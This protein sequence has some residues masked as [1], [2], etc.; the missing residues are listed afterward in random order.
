MDVIMNH[1]VNV[2]QIAM[3]TPQHNPSY[4]NNTHLASFLPDSFLDEVVKCLSPAVPFSG[5]VDES[6]LGLVVFAGPASRPA[7]RTVRFELS[8]LSLPAAVWFDVVRTVAVEAAADGA[9]LLAVGRDVN[10]W[11]VDDL[12]DL[13]SPASAAAGERAALL[14]EHKNQHQTQDR[15]QLSSS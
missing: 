2:H 5:P 10:A 14:D 15:V 11:A 4:H 8:A 3:D 1:R 9:A 12:L 7:S 6:E 13:E